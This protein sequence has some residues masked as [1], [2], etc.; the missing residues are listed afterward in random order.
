M[1]RCFRL[2]FPSIVFTVKSGRDLLNMPTE[3]LKV[4]LVRFL[5]HKQKHIIYQGHYN[6][7]GVYATFEDI[8]NVVNTPD[9]EIK[10]EIISD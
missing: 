9:F 7:F 8:K 1:I 6:R 5:T 10:R 2:E 4:F 3:D